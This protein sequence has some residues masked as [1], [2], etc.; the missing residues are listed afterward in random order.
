MSRL[1]IL[2]DKMN[3]WC[4][5]KTGSVD[6][7]YLAFWEFLSTSKSVDVVRLCIPGLAE[8]HCATD[9]VSN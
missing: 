6:R 9:L 3:G 4:T 1:R 5:F 2:P 8:A 7:T